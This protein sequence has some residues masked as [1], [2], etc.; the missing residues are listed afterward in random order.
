MISDNAW[1]IERQIAGRGV[2]DQ[3]VLAALRKIDRAQ[4]VPR[5]QREAAYSDGPLEI[6]AGQTISQPFIVGLMTELLRLQPADRVLEIGTGSG[7]QT[8]VLAG[9]AARVYSAE[10]E[11]VLAGR[12]RIILGEMGI[13]NVEFRIGDGVSVFRDQAPFDAI[14]S[15][16]APETVPEALIDQLAEGG[17]FVIPTG[18]ME[19]ELWL[20]E[21][22]GKEL[23]RRGV[24]P[25]RFVPLRNYRPK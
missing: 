2:S 16:A 9:L 1:M 5:A 11:P 15:A 25:V 19:Q 20:I 7:Y 24:L 22:R 4:F 23:L 18:G 8:A 3:R 6:G 14:L 17:R 21:K 10:I 12:A 13:G